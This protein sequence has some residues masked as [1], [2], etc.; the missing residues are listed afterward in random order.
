MPVEVVKEIPV[1]KVVTTEKPVEIIKKELV[2]VPFY[3]NDQN[4]LN[5]NE[6]VDLSSKP[7]TKADASEA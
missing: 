4:L 3:T 7:T 1:Q 6:T 5:S 2:H